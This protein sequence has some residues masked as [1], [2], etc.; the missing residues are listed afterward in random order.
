MTDRELRKLSRADLLELLLEQ[1]KEN[2]QLR[3]ELEAAQKQL[4]DR[5]ILVEKAGSIAEAS[6][7]LSGVFQAAQAACAQYIE[8]VERLSARQELL[9]A[10]MERETQ[11]KCDRMVA[12]AERQSQLYWNTVSRKVQEVTSSYA[13]L[14]SILQKPCEHTPE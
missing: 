1:L 6:L 7:Q 10:Q 13:E 12:E 4:A 3:G 11:A 9:C 2:E 14:R 8:N 5:K